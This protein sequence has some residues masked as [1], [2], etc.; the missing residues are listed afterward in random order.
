MRKIALWLILCLPG[1]R[2]CPEFVVMTPPHSG[3]HLL[4]PIIEQL[5]GK[6][7]HWPYDY[8]APYAACDE[9]TFNVLSRD[10]DHLAALWNTRPISKKR[11]ACMLDDL[12]KN[13][14]FLFLHTP[15]TREMEE[16]LSDRGVVVVT[17]KRDP[18]DRCISA[19][20]H[21]HKFGTGLIEGAWF[22]LLSC[23]EQLEMILTGTDWHNSVGSI[24]RAFRGWEGAAICC[25]LSFDRLVGPWGG[26]PSD[27][28]QLEELRKL[29]WVLEAEASDQQLREIFC[30][31]YAT[32]YTFH[33]GKVG[34]WQNYFNEEHKEI[35]DEQMRQE[36][37]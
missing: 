24:V 16:F 33:P 17:I 14:R 34:M 23:D 11:F 35:Y 18:R 30:R 28:Q 15:H 3:S 2:A 26:G 4:I 5:T 19:L 13:N 9:E 37:L 32:G 31:V 8:L 22:Q 6:E 25:P 36:E 27:T 20:F 29:A 10:R 7:A 12:K 21:I 1:L